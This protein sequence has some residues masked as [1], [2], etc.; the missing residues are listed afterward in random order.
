MH[1]L[2]GRENRANA[3]GQPWKNALV[4]WSDRDASLLMSDSMIPMHA[5]WILLIGQSSDCVKEHV[6]LFR[7]LSASELPCCV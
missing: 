6:H 7:W 5:Q 4:D 3:T 1:F 2:I